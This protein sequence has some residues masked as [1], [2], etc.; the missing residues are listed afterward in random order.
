M[1]L[2]VFVQILETFWI[3]FKFKISL[4][5][6]ILLISSW[7]TGYSIKFPWMI[8]RLMSKIHVFVCKRFLSSSIQSSL[9][10]LEFCAGTKYV[11]APKQ[12]GNSPC[13]VKCKLTCRSFVFSCTTKLLDI[14]D[15]CTQAKCSI[16]L[17]QYFR[18]L[19]SC[20]FKCSY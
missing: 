19:K 2:R 17:R 6:T 4:L 1:L 8:W 20:D 14:E 12:H 10:L 16:S 18:S 7:Q 3:D 11:L 9:S 13:Q 5:L 15:V